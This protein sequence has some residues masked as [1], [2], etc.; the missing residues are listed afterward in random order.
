MK[1]NI[2]TKV[3]NEMYFLDTFIRYYLDLGVDE[4]H[5]FDSESTDKTI[6]TIKNWH[7]KH[8][9]IQLIKSSKKLLHTSYSKETEVCNLVL[10]HTI[11][12]YKKNKEE[13]WWIFAD[14]DEFLRPP[15]GGLRNFL[16]NIPAANNMIRCVFLEW[17]L[18]MEIAEQRI[19]VRQVLEYIKEGKARGRLIDLWGDP[20][21]KDYVLRF[22]PQ[23]ITNF[24]QFRTIAGNHR[25][26]FKGETVVPQNSPFLIVDHLRGVF[27]DVTFSRI[28]QG[29]LLLEEAQ[30]KLSD[31][32]TY[33]HFKEKKKEVVNYEEFYRTA[34]KSKEE[35]ELLPDDAGAYDN[36]KSLYNKMIFGV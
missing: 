20:F 16:Q 27:I 34:L 28:N 22:S 9:G 24:A 31:N 18:P 7:K 11:N 36:S 5:F 12:D 29:L 4:I 2:V 3:L 8:K 15:A 17:Y 19:S 6:E 30:R 32:M 25:Y 26:L 23:T 33:E 35:V 13:T 14:I 1:I 10:Q 21:Y